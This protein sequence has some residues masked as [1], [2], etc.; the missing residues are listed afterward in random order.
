MVLAQSRLA[1]IAESE[2]GV[3]IL[4]NTVVHSAVKDSQS[5]AVFT[6]RCV[7]VCYGP[8]GRGT[9]TGHVR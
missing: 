7:C 3:R 1:V 8:T 9:R 4:H 5:W 2:H 6:E